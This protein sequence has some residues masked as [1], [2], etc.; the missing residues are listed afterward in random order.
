MS[1]LAE[2]SQSSIVYIFLFL[3]SFFCG[4]NE[5]LRWLW[6]DDDDDDWHGYLSRKRELDSRWDTAVCFVPF[7]GLDRRRSI[8]TKP[9]QRFAYLNLK[10]AVYGSGWWL[11]YCSALLYELII[12]SLSVGRS[13]GLIVPAGKVSQTDD[14]VT[15]PNFLVRLVADTFLH[16]FRHNH[17]SREHTPSFTSIHPI[18]SHPRL[19]AP[20]SRG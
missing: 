11:L 3:I 2:C 19:L 6:D 4:C 14:A 15:S 5:A 18:P 9:G 12:I 1:T 7:I 8:G 20:F 13:L 16:D 17:Q 10:S